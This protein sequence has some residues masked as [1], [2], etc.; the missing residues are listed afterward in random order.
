VLGRYRNIDQGLMF[1]LNL[2]V[3]EPGAIAVGEAFEV[4]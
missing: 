4:L 1:G 3:E 2:V